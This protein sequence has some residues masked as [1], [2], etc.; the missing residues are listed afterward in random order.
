MTTKFI[1]NYVK[2]YLLNNNQYHRILNAG[3]GG[4]KY[5]TQSKLYHLDIAEKTLKG[6][7]NAYAGNII[8][9]PFENNFFDM[10]VCVGTVINYC[11]IEKA[12]SEIN[13]VLKKGGILIL[14]YERCGSAFVLP[15]LRNNDF[16]IFDHIYF[17]EPHQTL[18][19]SDR[20]VSILLKKHGF[21]IKKA[22]KFNVALPF[23]E[24]FASE[25]FAHKVHFFEMLFR[26]L[27]FISNYA[28]N[29]IITC[30]KLT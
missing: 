2:K 15:K 25:E 22:A 20:Y 23:I 8:K 1:D 14:E 16:T 3:S 21:V 12:I 7:E 5:K 9:M 6:V 10:I 28:H 18:L 26:K 30:E 29:R 24:M 4:K 19:Y 17:G 27:P 13:R 11:E